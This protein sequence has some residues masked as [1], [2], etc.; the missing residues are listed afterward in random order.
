MWLYV[1]IKVKV[2]STSLQILCGPYS[3][4]AGGLHLTEM[5]LVLRCVLNFRDPQ[6]ATAPTITPG[7]TT[8]EREPVLTIWI[9][10]D[11]PRKSKIWRL[12]YTDF[13]Y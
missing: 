10:P 6:N 4:Q 13:K 2:I 8:T 5:L 12:P 11:I 7:S 1:I 3:L 9:R